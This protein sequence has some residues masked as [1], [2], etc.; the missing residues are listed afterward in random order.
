MQFNDYLQFVKIMRMLYGHDVAKKFFEN[1]T[2]KLFPNF[3]DKD[4]FKAYD[5]TNTGT[6][7]VVIVKDN[8]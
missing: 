6:K 8:I 4:F 7:K 1:N 5:L 3:V 2:T